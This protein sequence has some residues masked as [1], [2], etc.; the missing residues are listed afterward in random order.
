MSYLKT[1]IVV[2]RRGRRQ[3]LKVRAVVGSRGVRHRLPILL[4]V[5]TFQVLAGLLY[6]GRSLETWSPSFILAL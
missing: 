6:T 3:V 2:R 1:H 4:Q 5:C